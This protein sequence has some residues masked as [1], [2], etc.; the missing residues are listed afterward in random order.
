[1]PPCGDARERHG[2]SPRFR[3][4]AFVKFVASPFAPPAAWPGGGEFL[5]NPGLVYRAQA[6]AEDRRGFC[7]KR[8]SCF[9]FSRLHRRQAT[10]SMDSAC[11]KSCGGFRIAAHAESDDETGG[12]DLHQNR[13]AIGR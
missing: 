2:S 11:G 4:G 13:D 10:L 12:Y 1:L 3:P 6:G 9:R 7:A 5:P 8:L